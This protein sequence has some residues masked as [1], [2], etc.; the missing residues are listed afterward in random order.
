MS[1]ARFDTY[2]ML[3]ELLGYKSAKISFPETELMKHFDALCQ[4]SN[5]LGISLD[6]VEC[7][8]IVWNDEVNDMLHVVLALYEICDLDNEDS[9]RVMMNA[10]DNGKSIA[11][12]GDMVD[13]MEMV[14]VLRDRNIITSLEFR[15][16]DQ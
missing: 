9:M 1:T 11:R 16:S 2:D 3:L 15:R 14:A 10:H 5:E 12:S 4:L 6:G 13:L 8:L 7:D